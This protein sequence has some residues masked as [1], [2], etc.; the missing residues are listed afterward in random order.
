MALPRTSSC[1]L[2]L[3][4]AQSYFSLLQLLLLL[5]LLLL[6]LLLQRTL[7]SSA[8]WSPAL[9][10]SLARSPRNPGG[11]ASLAGQSSSTA[12]HAGLDL[13]LAHT[14]PPPPLL[15]PSYPLLPWKIRV[16][17][18][19]FRRGLH[20]GGR[21]TLSL[22]M[23]TTTGTDIDLMQPAATAATTAACPS[24]P[25]LAHTHGPRCHPAM[26]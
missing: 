26:C 15:T 20:R 17:L 13:E 23:Q 19:W 14:C 10:R 22:P 5:R 9:S 2:L 4:A 7:R 18:R 3:T 25:T 16:V 24:H 6:L 21:L 11:E 8:Q 1:L 12:C